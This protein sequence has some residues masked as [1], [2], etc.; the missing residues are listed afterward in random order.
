MN[1]KR[2]NHYSLIKKLRDEGKSF[3]EFEIV[4]NNLSLE[5]IIGL[6]LELSSRGIRGGKL[7]GLPIMFSLFDIVRDA[8]LKWAVSATRTKKEGARFLG[9]NENEYSKMLKTYEIDNYFENESDKG[10]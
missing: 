5:E 3:E 6:K 10:D 1:P 8:V 2:N 4:L 9:V 7:Y